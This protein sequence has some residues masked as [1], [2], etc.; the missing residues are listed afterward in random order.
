MGWLV[1]GREIGDGGGS[2][3]GGG[4]KG[5]AAAIAVSQNPVNKIHSPGTWIGTVNALL[6]ARTSSLSVS[7]GITARRDDFL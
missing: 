3:G 5:C 7:P 4:G 6:V 2:G 1:I